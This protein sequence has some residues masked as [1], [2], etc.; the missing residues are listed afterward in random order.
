MSPRIEKM[1]ELQRSGKY[2][3]PYSPT[4]GTREAKDAAS[5]ALVLS[6]IQEHL[7]PSHL[8]LDISAQIAALCLKREYLASSSGKRVS[9]ITDWDGIFTTYSVIAD[10]S[11]AAYLDGYAKGKKGDPP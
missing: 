3:V 6:D 8:P 5:N 2:R 11:L 7:R 4:V 10:L 9:E 1:L